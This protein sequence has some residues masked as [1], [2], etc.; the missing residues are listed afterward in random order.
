MTQEAYAKFQRI[1]NAQ[2]SPVIAFGGSYGGS[3]FRG[4]SP[5]K[6]QNIKRNLGTQY[7]MKGS[8]PQNSTFGGSLGGSNIGSNVSRSGYNQPRGTGPQ[9]QASRPLTAHEENL[10]RRYP[11]EEMKE[12]MFGRRE[13]PSGGLDQS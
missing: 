10:T 1:K 13:I 5:F 6:P 2:K 4:P 9:N 3:G 12:M 7:R 8:N 11:I